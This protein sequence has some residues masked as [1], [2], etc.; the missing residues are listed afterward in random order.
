LLTLLNEFKAVADHHKYR[1]NYD[2]HL[3]TALIN[4]EAYMSNDCLLLLQNKSIASQVSVLH[5]EF[6]Q[7]LDEL[8]LDLTQHQDEIQCVIGNFPLNG[9]RVV[10]FGAAQ[11]PQLDDYADGVDTM[12]FLGGLSI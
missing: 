1:N 11:C 9:F 4:R 2:Y 8:S 6:Y 5:Y 12:S 7:N 10:S 3:A